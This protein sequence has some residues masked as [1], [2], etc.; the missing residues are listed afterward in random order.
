MLRD[1]YDLGIAKTAAIMKLSEAAAK[2]YTADAMRKPRDVLA[3][4]A[5]DQREP[6]GQCASPP[7]DTR[8]F[9]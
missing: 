6:C 1:Q 5:S 7:S 2:R 8:S 4:S 3:T 9:P